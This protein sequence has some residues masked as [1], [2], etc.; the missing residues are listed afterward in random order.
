[1]ES[2]MGILKKIL[3]SNIMNFYEGKSTNVQGNFVQ[4]FMS[5]KDQEAK[6]KNNNKINCYCFSKKSKTHTFL[7]EYLFLQS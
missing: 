6:K 5:S 3:R 4:D 2:F 7:M 1:M